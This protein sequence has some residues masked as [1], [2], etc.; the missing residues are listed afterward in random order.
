MNKE[1]FSN[2]YWD[3]YLMLEDKF[4]E[5]IQYVE[6]S[7]DNYSCYSIEFVALLSL[8]GSEI[9]VVMKTISGFDASHKKTIA[10]YAPKIMQLFPELIDQEIKVCG[11]EINLQPFEGWKKQQ[12]AKSLFWWENYNGV[13]HGRVENLKK[14][15]LKTVLYILASLYVLESFWLKQIA[16]ANNEDDEPYKKS[17][18]FSLVNWEYNYLDIHSLFKN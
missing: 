3:Y 18:L 15:N 9:D 13:K 1:K 17:R 2:E 4:I 5:A 10:D 7:S 14:A 16:N 8:F 6:L 12:A 11:R